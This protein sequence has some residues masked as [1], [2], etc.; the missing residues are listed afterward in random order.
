MRFKNTVSFY[1]LVVPHYDIHSAVSQKI[2]ALARLSSKSEE[3]GA[4]CL[5]PVKSRKGRVAARAV[6]QARDIFDLFILSSQYDAPE[7]KRT[8]NTTPIAAACAAAQENIFTIPFE[9]FRDT[10]VAYLSF[11]D[12]AAYGDPSMWDEITLKTAQFLEEIKHA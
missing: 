12:Q 1:A 9:Q 5:P 4:P 3:A 8:K 10:V 11:E 6:T 2:D 7:G